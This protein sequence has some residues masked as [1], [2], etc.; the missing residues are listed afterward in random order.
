M[1]E[2]NTCQIKV[3]TSYWTKCIA[4]T[5]SRTMGTMAHHYQY[6]YC[7]ITKFFFSFSKT[8]YKYSHFFSLSI[9][10]K[11]AFPVCT[12]GLGWLHIWT[13]SCVICGW[14]MGARVSVSSAAWERSFEA[15]S[16]CPWCLHMSQMSER[17]QCWRGKLDCRTSERFK[18]DITTYTATATGTSCLCRVRERH[19]QRWR[20]PSAKDI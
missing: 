10:I 11:S 14:W 16:G 13:W 2:L 5:S 4:T 1:H 20:K 8:L 19:F 9:L 6:P 18:G 12:L 7:W 15:G 17:V 3:C